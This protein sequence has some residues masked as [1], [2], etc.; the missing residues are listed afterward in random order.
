MNKTVSVNLGGLVFQIDE[1]AYDVLRKYLEIIRQRF[2]T[3]EGRDE[4][5]TDIEY[6]FAEIFS[7]KLSSR[8]EVI[9]LD[10]VNDAINHMGRP[11]DF[12]NDEDEK[13]ESATSSASTEEK[14][15]KRLYRNPDDK[16]L[17]GVCS[18]ISAYLGISDP[19]WIRLVFLIAFFGFGSGFLIYIILWIIMPKAE[20]A[21]EKLQMSGSKV[22]VQNIEKHIREEM[23]G[24]KAKI[25]SPK[26]RNFFER[27]GGLISEIGKSAVRII[28]AIAGVFFIVLG[29]AF[30]VALVASFLSFIGIGNNDIGL[31]SSFVFQSPTHKLLSVT[32]V[33][34]MVFVI[35]MSIILLGFRGLLFRKLKLKPSGIVLSSLGLLGFFLGIACVIKLASQF[36]HHQTIKSSI[37]IAAADADTLYLDLTPE[38]MDLELH[39]LNTNVK[40]NYTGIH[41][42]SDGYQSHDKWIDFENGNLFISNV[43]LDIQKSKSSRFELVQEIFSRGN[44]HADALEL[45]RK[46]NYNIQQNDSLLLFQN[47]VMLSSGEKFRNQKVKL[48]LYVPEGKTVF[49]SERM[50]DI[51]YDIENAQNMWDGNMVNHFWKMKRT[52]LTC[53][54]CDAELDSVSNTESDNEFM[55]NVYN[56]FGGE[57][58]FGDYNS[59]KE[60]MQTQSSYRSL[61]YKQ[62]GGEEKFGPYSFF[63]ESILTEQ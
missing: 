31:M 14:V 29:V 48:T 61:V 7:E 13:T 59:F 16:Y 15:K 8:K 28:V 36:D 62:Y 26:V 21:S 5:I 4:I 60:L 24:V 54:D 45:A 9:V 27:L 12:L 49:L 53:L 30:F 42:Y 58:E 10:D 39:E 44:D 37:E 52:E 6:R 56:E 11:E 20:T 23:E 63:E 51:I 33:F 1:N 50:N 3:T 32:A 22:N 46:V 40:I 25:E 17:G 47:Y 43:T 19:I 57:N 35:S 18:G 34:L 41:I 38:S 55:K 2:S